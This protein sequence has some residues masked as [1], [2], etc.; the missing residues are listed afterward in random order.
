MNETKNIEALRG[1]IVSLLHRAFLVIY[2]LLMINIPE[3]I[4]GVLI[5]GVAIVAYLFISVKFQKN[6]F[7][8]RFIRFVADIL[9]I[10][11]ILLLY[12]S[13]DLRSFCFILL[14]L[15]CKSIL[16][17]SNFSTLLYLALPIQYYIL[18][19]ES[20]W[21]ISL[22]FLTLF[23]LYLL[24][25]YKHEIYQTSSMLDDVI[26]EFFVSGQDQ[27]KSY[28][29]YKKALPM[30]NKFPIKAGLKAIYCFR[31]IGGT[32]YIVNGSK[33][34]YKS[35]IIDNERLSILL[36]RE[37]KLIRDIKVNID[38]KVVLIK[39]VYPVKVGGETYLFMLQFQDNEQSR[40]NSEYSKI[41][42]PRFFARMANVVDSER[43]RK[44]VED[45]ALRTM[46]VKI[47]YVDAATDTMH[48]IRNKLS[49]LSSYITMRRDYDNAD[50]ER[51]VRILPY[52][53]NV[54]EKVILSYQMIKRRA[55]I[56][57]EESDNPL[58]YT[59]T[60]PH[61]IQQL[62]SEIRNHWQSYGLDEQ[63]VYIDLYEKIEGQ[64]SYI[65]YN[66][67]GMFLVLD[68]WINNIKKH[69]V[70]D[71]K[72]T[73][74]E[75]SSNYSVVFE[76]KVDTKKNKE[77]VKLFSSDNRNEIVKRKWHGLQAMKEILQQMDVQTVMTMD[78]NTVKFRITLAKVVRNEESADN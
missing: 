46:S 8:N 72:V 19:K 37:E 60:L 3:S 28:S 66:T 43:K 14:P 30:F 15:F 65:Y 13:W 40:I 63:A 16:I 11:Y 61:G 57:L 76:N 45:D 25:T 52:L 21:F 31:Y 36:K 69:G 42:Y 34:I 48:F 18:T 74:S 20:I 9:F 62:Y 32:Y 54:Y 1:I 67:D 49:P 58:V 26:D 53:N 59:Q 17:D 10:A 22:P 12:N 47:H 77:F 4:R 24:G 56:M 23:F 75:S 33:F 29:I 55:D 44:A 41:L 6:L 73:I 71:S 27:L 68:N 35:N 78:G 39:E 64:K 7:W 2:A 51:K 38:G 50:D 70:G 5:L